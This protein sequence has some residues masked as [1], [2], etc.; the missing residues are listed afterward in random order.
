MSG[1]VVR[2]SGNKDQALQEALGHLAPDGRVAAAL[3]GADPAPGT[4]VQ[5]SGDKVVTAVRHIPAQ[6]ARYVPWP[7]DVDARLIEALAARGIEQLYTHQ[8]EAMGHA[9]AGRHVVVVT[10]TASGKTLC[11]NGPVLSTVL[12]DPGARGAVPVPHQGAGA[13]SARR[14]A[15]A[16]AQIVGAAA[17]ARHRRVHLRRRHAGRRAAR[18]SRPRATSCSAIP[19]CCTRACCRTTRAGRSSSRTS[20]TSSSTN[21]TPTAAC[22]AATSRT[23]CAGCGASAGTTDRIRRSS[24][25]RRRLPTRRSWPSSSPSEPFELV[26]RKRRAARREVLRASSTRRS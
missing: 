8:A 12:R 4:H 6:T 11:Y 15:G 25:R 14:A 19:T 2:L 10:P 16:V 20:A 1:T 23:C 24:A 18:D 7:A 13:G 9:L 5:I 22:S 3:P 17:R 21:C 26:A